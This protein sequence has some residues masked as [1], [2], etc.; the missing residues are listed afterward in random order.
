MGLSKLTVE[1]CL[2]KTV[3]SM[4][5]NTQS[6]VKVNGIS[7]DILVKLGLHHGSVLSPL[8]FIIMLV[9]PSREIR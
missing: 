9:A 5:R 1:Q 2:V 6:C 4:Y 8:L 3:Q 7:C